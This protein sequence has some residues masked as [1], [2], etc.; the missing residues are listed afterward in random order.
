MIR[1]K[2]IYDQ[3][4]EADG[5]RILVDRLWPRGMKKE[6]AR[7]DLWMKEIAPSDTLRR[8]F[9]HEPEKWGEF[10]RLY[11]KELDEKKGPVQEM[12]RMAEK[13]TITLLYSARNTELNNA[14]ALKEYLDERTG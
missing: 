6:E 4:D 10:R 13:G 2:R 12:L 7:I 14:V 5:Y 3:F 9:R 1:V 8:D 11:F